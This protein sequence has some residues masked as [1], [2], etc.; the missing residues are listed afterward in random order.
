MLSPILRGSH[1]RPVNVSKGG[2]QGRLEQSLMCNSSPEAGSGL[3]VDA[4]E[5]RAYADWA[6][7][8]PESWRELFGRSI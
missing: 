3:A 4:Q 5:E 1:S 7:A 8:R 2:Q 6:Y